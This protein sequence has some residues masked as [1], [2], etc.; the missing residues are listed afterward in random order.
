MMNNRMFITFSLS[1]G[2][3]KNFFLVTFRCNL[4]GIFDHEI[5]GSK[6]LNNIDT[7]E[8]VVRSKKLFMCLPI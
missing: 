4:L 1:L 7:P 2:E 6:T 8:Q 5:S 3:C